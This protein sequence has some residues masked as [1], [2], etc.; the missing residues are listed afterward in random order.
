MTYTQPEL[1]SLL[2]YWRKVLR[3]QDWDVRIKLVRDRDMVVAN[4]QGEC[5]ISLR[6]KEALIRLLDPIDYPDGDWAQDHEQTLVH[7][8]L[9]LHMAPFDP[10]PNTLA[11][12]MQEQAIES[13]AKALVSLKREV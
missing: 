1:V 13:I 7:E 3:L 6:N 9:H 10:A 8:L 5:D 12:D 11:Q 2:V 4:R